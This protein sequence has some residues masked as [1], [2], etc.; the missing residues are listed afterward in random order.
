MLG[1][2][3]LED[4]ACGDCTM[5]YYTIPYDIMPHYTL[6]LTILCYTIGACFGVLTKISANAQQYFKLVRNGLETEEGLSMQLLNLKHV[7][8]YDDTTH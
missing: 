2:R 5:P 3:L 4:Q 1:W 6:Y 8:C 7:G